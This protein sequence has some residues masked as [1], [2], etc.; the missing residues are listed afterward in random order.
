MNVELCGNCG[1][2]LKDGASNSSCCLAPIRK[3]K[4]LTL[5]EAHEVLKKIRVSSAR[6][7]VA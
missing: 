7:Q 2:I 3:P 6:L 1:G 5:R 4:A